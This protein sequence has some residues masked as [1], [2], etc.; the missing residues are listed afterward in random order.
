MRYL[1]PVAMVDTKHIR[2]LKA[3]AEHGTL[4]AAARDLGYSQPAVSQQLAGLER[5][6]MT[7]MVLRG[8]T[9]SR[10]TEAGEILLHRG[11]KAL[12]ELALGIIEVQGVRDLKAGRIR[13]VAFPSA[14]ATFIAAALRELTEILPDTSFHFMSEI[15]SASALERLRA[16]QCE[17]AVIYEY[18]VPGVAG[19]TE[20]ADRDELH[21]HLC[22]ESFSVALPS[23]HPAAQTER[24][25]LADCRDG[26]WVAGNV[27]AR[28][29]I[30]R[31]CRQ[32]GFEPHFAFETDDHLALQSLVEAGVALALVSEYQQL[33]MPPRHGIAYRPIPAMLERR[34]RVVT[35]RQ[36]LKVPG[37]AMTVRQLKE[38][39]ARLRALSANQAR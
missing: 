17:L 3:I 1:Y 15:D 32:A 8:T 19:T 2:L 6:L 30:E 29:N 20:P 28:S 13:M 25:N 5:E 24:F 12:A 26:R 31:V 36:L 37:V 23:S 14:M 39:E 22:S 33:A 16:G 35:T 10:L 4:S 38:S 9:T 34:T 21:I 18:G 27:S 11:E 7:P